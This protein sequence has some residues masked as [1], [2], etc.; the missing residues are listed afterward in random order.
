[1][2][3]K[4]M[5]EALI[6]AEEALNQGEVPIGAVIV[7]DNKVIGRGHNEI[8]ARGLATAHAEMLAIRQAAGEMGDWRLN[9]CTLYVTLQPCRMCFGA[10]CL[11]RV[12]RIVFGAKQSEH[13]ACGSMGDIPDSDL[14]KYNIKVTGGVKEE[15]SLLILK[16]F[17]SNLRKEEKNGEMRELA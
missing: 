15:K 10:L 13:V 5:E 16:K 8:E 11:S 17:F 12:S 14:L 1:M 2:D 7:K 4:W 3:E 6:E 9:E